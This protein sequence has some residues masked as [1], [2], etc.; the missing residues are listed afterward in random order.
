MMILNTPRLCMRRL[1]EDDAT[2]I[3][4][5]LNEPSFLKHIGDRKV[6][7]LDDACDYIRGQCTGLNGPKEWGMRMIALKNG[8]PIGICG[9]L[10]REFLDHP[11]IGYALLPEYTG[12]GYAAEAADS[13]LNYGR[14]ALG[15]DRILAIVNPENDRSVKLLKK[16][17]MAFERMQP[18]QD[19]SH[20]MLFASENCHKISDR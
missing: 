6:R 10:K 8:A 11:D 15:F 12:Q 5:L 19:G 18:G 13:M 17:G 20:V 7:T 4:K 2:F 9:L 1:H 16:V 14:S 3:L